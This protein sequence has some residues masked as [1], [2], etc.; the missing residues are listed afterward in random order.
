[1]RNKMPK[2]MS[3][4][5]FIP[6]PITRNNTLK[7]KYG[8]NIKEYNKMFENQKGLCAICN[9]S[10]IRLNNRGNIRKLCVDHCHKTGKIRGLL[11]SNCNYLL[12]IAKD[13]IQT[14][15]N[16][17]KYLQSLQIYNKIVY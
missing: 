11:C 13:N 6:A 12:G 5:D 14:L 3:A 10:E 1:M 2:V 15:S 7:Y 16:A 17:I 4:K 8:I 9:N